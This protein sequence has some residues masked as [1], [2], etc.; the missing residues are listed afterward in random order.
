[1]GACGSTNADADAE[2]ARQEEAEQEQK[3]KGKKDDSPK[4]S[5]RSKEKDGDFDFRETLRGV[6]CAVLDRLAATLE[7]EG[8][9]F[10]ELAVKLGYTH[11][12]ELCAPQHFE[13]V[14]RESLEMKKVAEPEVERSNLAYEQQRF[15]NFVT[16]ASTAR[17]R[18]P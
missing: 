16:K 18:E 6:T 3:Q 4:A 12:M 5:P 9:R 13:K 14:F 1:M 8:E 15:V 7:M 11:Y 17:W 10:Q 2:A